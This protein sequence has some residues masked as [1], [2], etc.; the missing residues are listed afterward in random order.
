MD[1]LN[2]ISYFSRFASST[3]LSGS[4]QLSICEKGEVARVLYSKK[5]G[6]KKSVKVK[7]VQ[8]VS[9][10][11][12]HCISILEFNL[13]IKSSLQSDRCFTVTDLTVTY[14]VLSIRQ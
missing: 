8:L 9:S 5:I 4:N 13:T 6:S 11:K 14:V 12:L 7:L 2:C 3:R 1:N 10:F